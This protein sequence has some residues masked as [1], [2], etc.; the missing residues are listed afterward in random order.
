M[1]LQVEGKAK[2]S[3]HIFNDFPLQTRRKGGAARA[4]KNLENQAISGSTIVAKAIQVKA[5]VQALK[6][7][8]DRE[9]RQRMR[10]KVI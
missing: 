5:E 9:V 4:V 1:Q 7:K 6:E 10:E 2:T 8:R 3:N